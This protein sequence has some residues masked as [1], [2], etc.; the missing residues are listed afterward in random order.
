MCYREGKKQHDVQSTPYIICE[1][2]ILSQHKVSEIFLYYP[3][4]PQAIFGMG[5]GEYADF[6]RIQKLNMH[7]LQYVFFAYY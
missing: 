3:K 6:Q 1:P 7:F 4:N 2:P 5:G